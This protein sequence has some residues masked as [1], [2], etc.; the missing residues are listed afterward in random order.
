[1]VLRVGG[2]LK[3]A[4]HR[5]TRLIGPKQILEIHQPLILLANA[6]SHRFAIGFHR[7]RRSKSLLG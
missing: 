7:D 6:E 4:R 1:F 5:P 2:V 3:D